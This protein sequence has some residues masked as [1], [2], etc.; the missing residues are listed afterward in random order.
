[1]RAI[2][3]PI[4]PIHICNII[5]GNQTM[6]VRKKFPKDY[7]GWVYGYCKKK[8]PLVRTICE[9]SCYD[10]HPR[11]DGKNFMRLNEDFPILNG[12]IPF[13]FW[14]DHVSCDFIPGMRTIFISKLEAFNKLMLISEFK[15]INPSKNKHLPRY[16]EVK[17]PTNYSYIDI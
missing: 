14:C 12:K 4:E 2:L 9:A 11:Q 15:K 6:I 10:P 5:H 7:V 1:M 8:D 3:V 16:L 17:I 13:R